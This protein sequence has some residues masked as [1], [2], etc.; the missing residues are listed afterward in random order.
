V[1]AEGGELGSLRA[2]AVEMPRQGAGW[3]ELGFSASAVMGGAERATVW[4]LR[5]VDGA[6]W[7]RQP[8]G[9]RGWSL[10]GVG[11]DEVRALCWVEWSA[12]QCAAEKGCSGQPGGRSCGVRRPGASK[13]LGASWNGIQCGRRGVV[14][15][16][17][18]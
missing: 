16:G 1:V 15:G 8:W 4:L 7:E 18:E 13:V 10:G 9:Y 3:H 5:G 6:V 11:W 12:R 14:L 17:V 2:A